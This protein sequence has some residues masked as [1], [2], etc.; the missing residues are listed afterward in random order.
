[1][2]RAAQWVVR[3]SPP[4]IT[5]RSDTFPPPVI[6]GIEGRW[7]FTKNEVDRNGTADLEGATK[8]SLTSLTLNHDLVITWRWCLVHPSIVF[9]LSCAF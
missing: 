2:R 5:L 1:M 9:V 3:L 6:V 4:P 8:S 7:Q